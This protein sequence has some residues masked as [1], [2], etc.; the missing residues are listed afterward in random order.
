[1]QTVAEQSVQPSGARVMGAGSVAAEGAEIEEGT[2]LDAR[3]GGIYI[4]PGASIAPCRI[5][6]PAYIGPQAQVK[7]FST[8]VASYVGR[9][10]RVAGEVEH[11]VVSDY[12]NKAHAGYIGHS[13]VG[14]WVNI[15]AMTTTSDLKMT[16]GP[17]RMG[18]GRS[19]KDTGL[20]KLGS[21]F[22]DMSKTSIGT[23]VYSGRRIGVSSHLHGLVAD[24]VSSF[25]MYGEGIGAKNVELELASAI[26]TQRKMMGRRD[27]GMSKVYEQMMKKIFLATAGDRRKAGVR[28]ARF[29][30]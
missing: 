14:E 17:V 3:K 28:R 11:S 4:G 1:M 13:Y 12:S 20:D 7:Q 22:A 21:F 8:I 26:D 18:Q 6:G 5:V 27:Q 23:M 30:L 24:D 25:T 10:C 15:G 2:V 9:N 29:A 16:Y 19:R